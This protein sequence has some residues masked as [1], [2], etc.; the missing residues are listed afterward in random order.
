MTIT[1]HAPPLVPGAR[2]VPGFEG[3]YCCTPD[4]RLWS[5]YSRGKRK[6]EVTDR[7]RELVGGVDKDG[8]RKA[9]LVAA[10]ARHHVRVHAVV[11]RVFLGPVPTGRVCA[12]INGDHRDNRT[13]NLVYVSQAENIGHKAL[14]GT[15]A[16]GRRVPTAK[17]DDDQVRKIRAD[18]RRLADIAAEYGVSVATVKAVRYRKLWRHVAE[19]PA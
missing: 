3:L 9:I 1:T 5:F 8:Y 10:G 12:H 16:R 15:T 6:G 14:H 18:R 7:A 11:A 4:G 2:W 13:E 17:L 19:V